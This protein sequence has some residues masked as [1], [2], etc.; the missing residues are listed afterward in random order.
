M[1]LWLIHV[2]SEY[3]A[4]VNPNRRLSS[5]AP[6]R[7]GPVP[8]ILCETKMRLGLGIS[9]QITLPL[10]YCAKSLIV[11]ELNQKLK[12]MRNN[13]TM[14]QVQPVIVSLV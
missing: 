6:A 10:G 12:F 9:L 5:S 4:R 7:S 2:G 13:R 1:S 3:V 14:V 8:P 11:T